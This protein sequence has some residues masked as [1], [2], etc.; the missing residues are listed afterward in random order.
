MNSSC[1]S[2]VT[3]IGADIELWTEFLAEH[4]LEQTV[5]EQY[6]Q[7]LVPSFPIISARTLK[8]DKN[9]LE[10]KIHQP[11][12]F[13]ALS[14]VDTLCC[15]L[16]LRVQG[17]QTLLNVAVSRQLYVCMPRQHNDKARFLSGCTL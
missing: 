8:L 5:W 4:I 9:D 10:G 1:H 2:F 7:M 14:S 13:A 3:C 11:R 15:I 6:I 17:S 16:I 12:A